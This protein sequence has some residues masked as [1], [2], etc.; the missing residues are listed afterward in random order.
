MQRRQE[1]IDHVVVVELAYTVPPK[2]EFA[3]CC[4]AYRDSLGDERASK[5]THYATVEE[6]RQTRDVESVVPV[7]GVQVQILSV[8]R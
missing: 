8:A 5:Q 7:T 2:D 3:I 4:K 1:R 6:P